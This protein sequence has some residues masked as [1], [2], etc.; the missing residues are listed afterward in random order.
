MIPEYSA[1][2]TLTRSFS[3]HT[4]NT[5]SPPPIGSFASS[6]VILSP[7]GINEITVPPHA[8]PAS[9]PAD[10][11]TYSSYYK[12]TLPPP[13]LSTL[14]KTPKPINLR[15]MQEESRLKRTNVEIC[16]LPTNRDMSAVMDGIELVLEVLDISC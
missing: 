6:N 7:T 13:L 8:P 3:T 4:D 14:L 15:M 2:K 10:S 11:E 5:T 9:H 12:L 1:T 16:Q